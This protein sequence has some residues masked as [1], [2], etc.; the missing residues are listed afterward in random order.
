VTSNQYWGG[1]YFAKWEYAGPAV[2]LVQTGGALHSLTIEKRIATANIAKTRRDF[3]ISLII[4]P[5]RLQ[6]S[7]TWC[8]SKTHRLQLSFLAERGI[9]TCGSC[10]RAG[11]LRLR[12][13]CASLHSVCAQQDTILGGTE[14]ETHDVITAVHVNH[15]AGDA[16][17]GVGGK[18]NSCRANFGYFH[19]APQGRALGV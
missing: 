17:A 16:A 7:T 12:R 4:P 9:P 1:P 11:M 19:I 10:L 8:G 14:S 3:S 6:R 13:S 2:I 18:E 5:T 15:F